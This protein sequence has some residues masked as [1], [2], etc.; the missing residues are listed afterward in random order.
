MKICLELV[1]KSSMIK[2]SLKTNLTFRAYS[3]DSQDPEQLSIW[4]PDT[5]MQ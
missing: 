1:V 4:Q 5:E 2:I 3:V